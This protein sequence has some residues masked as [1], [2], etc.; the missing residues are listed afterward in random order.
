MPDSKISALTTVG[1]SQVD[2][3][4]NIPIESFGSTYKI[5]LEVLFYNLYTGYFLNTYI[6]P[7]YTGTLNDVYGRFRV[8]NGNF[9]I[10]GNSPILKA[11]NVTGFFSKFIVG[12]TVTNVATGFDSNIYGGYHNT[13][14]SNYITI[15]NG[16]KNF[17]SGDYS[18]V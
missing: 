1:R 12:D 7:A 2:I 18:F 11:D 8:V 3:G 10:S 17:A 13:G 15:V 16:Y 4:T 5:P 14:H 9:Y 6:D